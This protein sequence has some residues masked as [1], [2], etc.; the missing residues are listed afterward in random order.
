MTSVFPLALLLCLSSGLLTAY[1]HTPCPHGWRHCGSRCFSYNAGPKNWIDG[2]FFCISTG[3]NLASIH[4]AE[5]HEFIRHYIREVTGTDK[6]AWIGGHDGVKEGTF[7]WT[8]GSKFDF[9][10]FATGEPNDFGAGEDC[11]VMN[12]NGNNWNDGSCDNEAAFICSK[13]S[14]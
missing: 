4:S 1:G 8:D 6:N 12:F 3:G 9:T 2:E 5:E 13:N 11:V 7:L 14:V 10:S